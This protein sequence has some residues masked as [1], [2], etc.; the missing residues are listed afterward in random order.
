MYD[1]REEKGYR[2]KDDSGYIE[3]LKRIIAISSQKGGVGKSTTAINVSAFLGN[4]GY[5]TIIVDMDPQSNSTIGLGVDYDKIDISIYNILISNDD[6]NNAI[7]ETP[8][9]NLKILPANWKLSE[10]EVDLGLLNGREF[11]LR[12]TLEKIEY[13]YDFIVIDCP[14]YLGLLTI[15]VFTAAEEIIVPMQCEYFA[16]EG[17]GRLIDTIDSVREKFNERLKITGAVLTMYSKT[18]LANQAVKEIR[19]YFAGNVFKTI[20]P[21][22]IRLGEATSFGRPIS[23]YDPGCKGALAYRDLTL[24][25]IGNDSRPNITE[26]L[27]MPRRIR[28]FWS[29]GRPPRHAVRR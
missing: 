7:R 5:K 24:E 17:V 10:A 12:D 26:N 21:N 23:D 25:I 22:N 27:N 14:P 11:R 15:N 2:D 9:N 28:D 8:Y 6:P 18:K 20:I 3:P 4:F 16:L 1:F 13:D 19:K 29:A